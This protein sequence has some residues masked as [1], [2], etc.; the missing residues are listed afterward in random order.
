[1]G[2]RALHTAVGRC[3]GGFNQQ[4]RGHCGQ[5]DLSLVVSLNLMSLKLGIVVLHG[6]SGSKRGPRASN[7][8]KGPRAAGRHQSSGANMTTPP[9]QTWYSLEEVRGRRVSTN[10]T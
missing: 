6:V 3:A 4:S 7:I 8:A 10:K 9:P 1:M 2:I 5:R